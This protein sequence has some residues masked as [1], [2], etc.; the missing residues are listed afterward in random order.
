[1]R[2][3]AAQVVAAA[4]WLEQGAGLE[5]SRGLPVHLR[6]DAALGTS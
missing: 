3:L 5:P 6:P 1:L 2:E 4:E